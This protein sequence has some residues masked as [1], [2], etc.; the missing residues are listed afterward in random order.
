M[1][2]INEYKDRFFHLLETEIGDVKPIINEQ[3]NSATGETKVAGPFGKDV[4]KFYIF[5]KG[6]KFYI[7]QTNASQKTPI[8]MGGNLW[9]NTG[10]GYNTQEEANKIIQDQLRNQQTGHDEVPEFGGME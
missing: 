1:K 10:K 9:S 8:L 2:S 6:G 5:S 3:V 4:Q 7:Y